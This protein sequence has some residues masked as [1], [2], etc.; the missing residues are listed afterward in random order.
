MDDTRRNPRIERPGQEPGSFTTPGACRPVPPAANKIY[1]FQPSAAARPERPIP[2]PLEPAAQSAPLPPAEQL[3]PS[4]SVSAP[5]APQSAPRRS[6]APAKK[7]RV[8]WIPLAL[9]GALLLGVLAGAMLYENRGGKP[10][11]PETT[12]PAETAQSTT[13]APIQTTPP[14]DVTAKEPKQIFDENKA[15][16]VRIAATPEA[17]FGGEQKTNVATGFVLTEDGYILT[18]Y[19]VI[20]PAILGGEILAEFSDG[21]TL[22]AAVIAFEN[23][24]N[25]LALLKV[26]PD[27]PLQTVELG[28]SD[29]LAVGEQIAVIG[30]PMGE[31]SQ[32]LTVGYVSAKE[33]QVEIG[34]VSIPMLQTDAAINSGNSGGP[35]FDMTGRVVGVVTAKYS[36]ADPGGTVVEGLGFAI[37]IRDAMA[38]VTQWIGVGTND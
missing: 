36:G 20:G 19:H 6:S 26:E 5:S 34:G 28:D 3:T 37:P 1:S 16:V 13:A 33:R 23:R 25:D 31:L 30:N 38:L 8:W 12:E 11:A 18:N 21:R 9:I 24:T 35:M 27:G 17:V 14:S 2:A 29:A 22:R 4:A 7:R 10:A 32:T 15:A